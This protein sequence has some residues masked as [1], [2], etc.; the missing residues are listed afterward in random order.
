MNTL[1]LATQ[2]TNRKELAHY[3]GVSEK[4]VGSHINGNV[5]MTVINQLKVWCEHGDADMIM[6]KVCADQGG[7]FVKEMKL[8]GNNFK[9]AA[10]IL[11][12]F[13]EFMA[14]MAEGYLDGIV[15]RAEFNRMKKEWSECA[16]LV[17]GMFMAIEKEL[18]NG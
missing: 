11:K 16:A 3:L 6:R 8:K 17:Q 4:T 12:E 2:N 15:T 10:A 1:K 13:S 5:E 18:A 7:I 9:G 14:V